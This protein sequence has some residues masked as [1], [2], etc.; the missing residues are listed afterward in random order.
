MARRTP[1]PL[2]LCLALC[3]CCCAP[4]LRADEGRRQLPAGG[5]GYR[6]Q[7]VAV[8]KGGARLRAELTVADDAGAGASAFAA[9]GEDVRKL[10]VYA[11]CEHTR[12]P[13]IYHSSPAFE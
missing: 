13:L 5:G 2:L 3:L 7:A 12:T 9:Y 1:R 4:C 10:D 11:R 6:V 8:D